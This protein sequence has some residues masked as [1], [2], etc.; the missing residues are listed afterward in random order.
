MTTDL[1]LL[2]FQVQGADFLYTQKAGIL[3]FD[4][5]LG[6]T[7]TTLAV[8]DQIKRDK[9]EAKFL[10]VC[11][12]IL[13]YQWQTEINRFTPHLSSLVIDGHQGIRR[14][15]Y[16]EVAD[17]Y[18][19]NYELV[20]MDWQFYTTYKW[21]AVTL[22]EAHKI[23]NPQTKQSK[24]CRRLRAEYRFCLTGTPISNHPH[25]L[26]APLSWI[27]PDVAGKWFHF[28]RNY[29]NFNPWGGVSGAKNLDKLAAEIQPYILSVSK[30]DVLPELNEVRETDV[31]FELS[32][33]E[34]NLYN[35]IRLEQLFEIERGLINK[36]ASPV[37]IQN[38]VVK[39]LRLQQLTGGMEL[40][41][42]G[43][44]SSKIERI[45]EFV[46]QSEGKTIIYSRFAEM[47]KLLEKHLVAY[48]PFLMIGSTPKKMRQEMIDK[49]NDPEDQHKL[50]IISDTASHGLN[51]QFACSTIIY[52]ESPFSLGKKTQITGR[53]HR[54]GQTKQVNIY[55]M[56]AKVGGRK[57]IDH[58][59]K[60]ITIQK[61]HIARKAL[62]L[63]EV[64]ELLS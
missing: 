35:Q 56:L 10:I 22:D 27:A 32:Q 20:K 8:L 40:L 30:S 15:Q 33:E 46:A 25:E 61:S 23:G 43:K 4:V 24:V 49:F 7:I 1:P 12:A 39:A 51:L 38:A 59:I 45:K 53:V 11:P 2:P 31:E 55:Y 34:E 18:I 13:K 58:H 26:W 48:S 17:I 57:S 14:K 50:L 29:C 5:G 47:G 63:R 37:Q 36:V 62:G 44:R 42:Q 60:Q 28:V 16:A 41:G 21:S 54:Y 64:Q 3:A 9:P 19:A 52:C 6:K